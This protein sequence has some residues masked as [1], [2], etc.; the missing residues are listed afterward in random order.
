MVPGAILQEGK[1]NLN[2][3]A[4]KKRVSKLMKKKIKEIKEEIG[5]SLIVVRYF[6]TPLAK[7]DTSKQKKS[8]RSNINQLDSH[9]ESIL[10]V[11]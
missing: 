6:N 7:F 2:L 3:W 5:K 11:S 9:F 10:T 1:A 8:L 4:P